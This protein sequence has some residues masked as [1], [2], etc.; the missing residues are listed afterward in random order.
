MA[1]LDNQDKPY[2]IQKSDQKYAMFCQS[3]AF[4]SHSRIGFVKMP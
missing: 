3:I 2:R 4:T 1:K